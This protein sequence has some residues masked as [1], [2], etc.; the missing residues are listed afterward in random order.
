MHFAVAYR[1]LGSQYLL[2]DA[3]FLREKASG[4]YEATGTAETAAKCYYA[5]L[6]HALAERYREP[7]AGH[8]PAEVVRLAE[9]R[10]WIE[11]PSPPAEKAVAA[12]TEKT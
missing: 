11:L 12:A 8:A 5:C 7:P 2:P 1:K 6:A 3:L 10:V 4:G 9:R